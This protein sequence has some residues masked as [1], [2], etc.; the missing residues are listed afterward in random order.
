MKKGMDWFRWWHGAYTDPKMRMIASECNL[1]MASLLGLWASILELASD[2]NVRGTI[3]NFDA[4]VMSFHLGIDV[5]TPCNAMKRR[6]MLHETDGVLCVTNWEKWQPAR[7]RN[8]DSSERVAKHRAIKKQALTKNVAD[9]T[10]GNA[11]VTAVTPREEKNISKQPPVIPQ[12]AGGSQPAS[13]GAASHREKRQAVTFAK[14]IEAVR[15][16]GEKPVGDY[17]PLRQYMKT[18]G[19]PEE[20]VGLAWHAFKE[21]YTIDEKGKRK[22]YAEWR[23]VFLRSVK[24][25]WFGFWFI[26]RDNGL[27]L[28]TKGKQA[29]LE[30][31]AEVAA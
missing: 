5:V 13:D 24:E 10:P 2:S 20:F 15:A 3:D 28:T 14:W 26:D 9:V 19:L 31:A 18:V 29:D 4:E 27:Q 7:E 22:R 23:L 8:D 1:P 30:A 11:N 16:A 17:Q 25:N 21:R 12:Q 6:G